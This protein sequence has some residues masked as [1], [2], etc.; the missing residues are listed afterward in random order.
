[1]DRLKKFVRS[2]FLIKVVNLDSNTVMGEGWSSSYDF[3][4]GLELGELETLPAGRYLII[5]DARFNEDA[6][7]NP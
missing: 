6:N 7:K 2:R 3:H 4:Y 5:V 1:M